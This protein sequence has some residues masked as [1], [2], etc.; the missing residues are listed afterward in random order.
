MDKMRNGNFTSSEIFKLLS[1]P[2][3]KAQKEG[4]IFGA[5]AKTYIKECNWER[6][7]NR[8]IE[9]EVSARPTSWG[10]LCEYFA[11][12][13]IGTEYKHC[14]QD[15]LQHPEI[16]YWCGSP[17]GIKEDA[18]KTVIDFKCPEL[19]TFCELS[20]C[21]TIQEVRD[22]HKDGE[23][24][25]WQ[26][27][28]GACITGAKWA[29]LIVFLPFQNQLQEIR[30]SV[31]DENIVPI[32]QMYQY[33]WIKNSNDE[34]LVYLPNEGCQYSNI[35]IIRFEI[36]ESDKIALTTRVIEAGKLLIKPL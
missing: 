2:T 21:K 18:G 34:E 12:N 36:P 29:E 14:S 8:S 33:L 3:I 28:S 17:D 6:K 22:N 16:S 27:V 1:E 31:Q 30:D 10:C 13:Q 23:K 20:E 5:P 4:A 26:L 19:A 25:Y 7:L 15:T 32:D 9:K 24:Y 11:F 35:H